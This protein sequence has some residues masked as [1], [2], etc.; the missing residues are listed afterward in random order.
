M[1]NKIGIR[2]FTTIMQQWSNYA[3]Y[4]RFLSESSAYIRRQSLRAKKRLILF[5]IRDFAHLKNEKALMRYRARKF[6]E[7][8]ALAEY[9]RMMQVYVH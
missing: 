1:R 5:A 2:K 7:N 6:L 8:K 3:K 4:K 9:L